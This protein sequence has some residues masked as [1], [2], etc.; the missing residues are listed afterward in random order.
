MIKQV[1]LLMLGALLCAPVTAE[2]VASANAGFEIRIET[3]VD[4]P[5]AEVWAQFLAVGEW[6]DGEHSWFGKAENFSIEPRA[7]GCFCETEGDKSVLHMLVSYVNPQT[8]EM[9]MIGGLGPLQGLALHGAMVWK[10]EPTESGGTR[11]V[12]TY[13]VMGYMK[14]G[15]DTLA[16][17]VNRVQAIQVARLSAR[18]APSPSS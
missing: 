10:F 16:P 12:H 1:F 4:A 18:V 6:W 17:V 7:G 2:V 3:A 8:H 14:E 15:L 9:R 13:R 11:T 5:P